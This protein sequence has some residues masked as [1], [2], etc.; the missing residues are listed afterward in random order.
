MDKFLRIGFGLPQDYLTQALSR[1][2]ELIMELK[3]SQS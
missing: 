2:H 3:N 1:I